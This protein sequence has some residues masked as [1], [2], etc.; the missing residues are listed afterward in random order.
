M[1][2]GLK[3][4]QQSYREWTPKSQE[5]AKPAG[6]YMPGGDTRTTAHYLPYPAFMKRGEGCRLFDVDGHSYLDFMNNFTSLI[7][8][9]SHPKIN[10]AVG[11]QVRLGTAFA[12]PTESQT[13]LAEM[14]CRMLP[15]MEQ[16]RFCSCGSE[17]TLMAVRAARAFTG[18]QKIMKME[19]GYNGNH[20]LGE[21]SL[22]PLQP[23]SGP[24]EA[25]NTVLP[26][27]GVALSSAGDTITVP[28]NEPEI[29]R[30][31]IEKHR[32]DVA[33]IILEPMLGGL[34]MI[35]PKADYLK[36]LREIT[37]ANNVLLI[38]DE[39]IT[40]RLAPG[41]MQEIYEI[42]PDLTSTGKIIG[43]GLPI[44]AFGGRRE[45]MQQF[46][47]EQPD[48]MW[49]ASTFS[50]NPLTMAAGIAALNELTPDT[51][52]RLNRLGE[53]L[54]GKFNSAFRDCGIRGQ[55]VGMGSLVN[56]HFNDQPIRNARDSVQGFFNSG[57]LTMHLHLC[58]I[59]RGIFPASR[60]M[61]CISTPMTEREI[62]L[63]AA[64]FFDA[65]KELKP[66][67]EEDFQHLLA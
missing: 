2:P 17:A 1:N 44:G 23:A 42:K 12:A 3:K 33:A 14:V 8:G 52:Q 20:D 36:Q 30:Q 32:D 7:H 26:D 51:Y 29:A 39:V 24:L 41:G 66:I 10:E 18:K 55:A 53:S 65:L 19:G 35:P 28:F 13:Q 57:P 46:N 21:L 16:V 37:A 56:L 43:G 45:I 59:Q 34:G 6:R 60:Q 48:F 40:L 54:K 25:P 47:P 67:I 11:E 31:L 49:H 50:G 4:I 22:V 15:S 38:L 62:D 58:M 61:Y 63:A 27:K 64:A 9:H 5:L